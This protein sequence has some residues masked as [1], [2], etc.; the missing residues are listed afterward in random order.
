MLPSADM[1]E[2]KVHPVEN[3]FKVGQFG[4]LCNVDNLEESFVMISCVLPSPEEEEE[5]YRYKHYDVTSPVPQTLKHN[6][7]TNENSN[8]QLIGISEFTPIEGTINSAR[9]VNKKFLQLLNWKICRENY[10]LKKSVNIS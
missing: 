9:T 10:L 4:Y 6:T 1:D 7:E 8:M 3:K 5:K 2:E